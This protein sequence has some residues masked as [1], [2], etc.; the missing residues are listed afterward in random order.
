M[1]GALL[2]EIRNIYDHLN[3]SKMARAMT[4][5]IVMTAAILGG[6]YYILILA[7]AAKETKEPLKGRVK[8]QTIHYSYNTRYECE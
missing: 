8:S 3:G 5:V 7:M 6:I 2:N 4:I 1:R